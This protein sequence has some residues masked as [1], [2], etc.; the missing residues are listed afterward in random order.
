MFPVNIA[1]DIHCRWIYQ[2]KAA[3]RFPLEK[4]PLSM[5]CEENVMIEMFSCV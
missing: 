4:S 1:N 3:T 5:F 2:V